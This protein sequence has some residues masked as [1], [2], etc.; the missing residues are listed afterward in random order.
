MVGVGDTQRAVQR[1]QAITLLRVVGRGS[2]IVVA[3]RTPMPRATSSGIA[4]TTLAKFC[5]PRILSFG[6]GSGRSSEI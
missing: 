4:A 2:S 6:S 5:G 3:I 1:A